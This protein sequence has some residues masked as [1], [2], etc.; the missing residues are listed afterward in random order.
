MMS[1]PELDESAAD[2]VPSVPITAAFVKAMLRRENQLRWTD[3]FQRDLALWDGVEKP[4]PVTKMQEKVASEFGLPSDTGLS[5]I[6]SATSLFPDDPEI[7]ECS[8]YRKYNHV[9]RG[10]VSFV[11]FVPR[12]VYVSK[13]TTAVKYSPRERE[14]YICVSLVAACIVLFCP[15]AVPTPWSFAYVPPI[16]L[17]LCL[18]FSPLFLFPSPCSRTMHVSLF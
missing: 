17:S 2:G 6:R 7:D 14:C 1:K 4:D 9:S 11:P 3:E 5:I 8:M 13:A 15:A 12:L 18:S 16:S 10:I